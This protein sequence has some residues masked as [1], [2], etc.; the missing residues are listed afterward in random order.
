MKNFDRYYDKIGT[1]D[2]EHQK[3]FQVDEYNDQIFYSQRPVARF[4]N[5]KNKST[6]HNHKNREERCRQSAENT[7]IR[8]NWMILKKLYP[9]SLGYI[10]IPMIRL[11]ELGYS[12]LAPSKVEIAQGT[13]NYILTYYDYSMESIEKDQQVIIYYKKP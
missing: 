9:S 7:L 10:P 3:Y 6:W 8:K 4:Q 1:W 11:T 5:S 13:G 2:E 12:N